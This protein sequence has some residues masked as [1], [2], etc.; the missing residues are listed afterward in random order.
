M[1]KDKNK[2]AILPKVLAQDQNEPR[3]TLIIADLPSARNKSL[4]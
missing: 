1:K 2:S 4:E 3:F